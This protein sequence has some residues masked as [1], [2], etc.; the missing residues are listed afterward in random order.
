MNRDDIQSRLTQILATI[1]PEMD[2]AALDPTLDL[3][4][5]LDIDSMDLL[6]FITA[7]HKQLGVNIPEADYP[8]LTSLAAC[9]DYVAERR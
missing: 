3:R 7:I 5:Q 9:V 1:A 4:E 8:R 2:P 6:N